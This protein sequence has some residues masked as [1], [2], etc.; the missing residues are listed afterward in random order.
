MGAKVEF[1]DRERYWNGKKHYICAMK[2]KVA[3][4]GQG[5]V[6]HHLTIAL[7]DKA[8]VIN[9]NSR[10]LTGLETNCD[11]YIIS[12]SDDAIRDVARQLPKLNGIILHTSGSTDM[13]ILSEFTDK[14]GVL[15]P[16]QTFTK[17]VTLNYSEIPVFVEGCNNDVIQIIKSIAY[18]ISDKVYLA[19]SQRRKRLH[20]ASV[21]AC[22]YVNHMWHIAD[23]VLREDNMDIRML[24][25]LIEATLDKIRKISPKDAQTGPAI[26]HD[27]SIIESHQKFLEED[28]HLQNLYTI[29]ADDIM[30]TTQQK[31]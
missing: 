30:Q 6:S 24:L 23:D 22:N 1:F 15:Y 31:Q 16:L 26:R 28:K 11:A 8:D 20:V 18:I 17:G 29:I 12:V 14:Y 27:L 3:I 5:N 10:T 4:I 21:F 2:L 25:P 7:K 19:N 13:N 9:I